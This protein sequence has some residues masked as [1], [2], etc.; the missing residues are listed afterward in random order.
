MNQEQYDRLLRGVAEWN[1]WREAHCGEVIDLREANLREADLREA[2]LREADLREADLYGADLDRAD[3]DRADLRRAKNVLSMG[4]GGSRGDMLH[5]VR[6][7]NGVMIY[8]GCFKGNIES[9]L[10]QVEHTHGDNEHG[11]YYRAVVELVRAWA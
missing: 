3:L 9:F 11:R 4:P 2:D 8:C 7:D 6:G 5:A 10:E 1:E